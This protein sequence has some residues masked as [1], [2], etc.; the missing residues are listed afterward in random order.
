VFGHGGLDPT[1]PRPCP[2]PRLTAG[3]A[4]T[5]NPSNIVG[6]TPHQQTLILTSTATTTDAN[7]LWP[8]RAPPPLPVVRAAASNSN[9][10]SGPQSDREEKRNEA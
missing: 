10:N 5:P 6:A 7:P 2:P 9:M 1:A 3:P 8:R 4:N